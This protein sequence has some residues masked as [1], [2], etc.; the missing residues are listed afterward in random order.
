MK[1][2]TLLILTYLLLGA[3]AS[4]ATGKVPGGTNGSVL[5]QTV[6]KIRVAEEN[7]AGGTRAKKGRNFYQI[8][9]YHLKSPAQEQ[10]L[11]NFLR[12]AYLPALHRANIRKVGVFKPIQQDTA[13]IRVYVLIPFRSLSEFD[14][15]G[16]QLAKD[17]RYQQSGSDY[18]NAPYNNAPYAR[19]E[20]ILL[21]AFSGSP[22]L[23]LPKLT[24]PKSERVYE[25]RSYEGP[26]EKYYENK[27]KM[28]NAGNEIAIFNRLGFNAV[29][30][31]EVMSGS[32]MPNLMYLTTFNNQ[33]DRDAHWKAFSA[34]PDW[35]KLSALEEYKNNVSKNEQFFLRPAEYSDI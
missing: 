5:T 20:S 23:T 31:G 7:T 19:M 21:K 27:V 3:S 18:I 16:D 12:Q 13:D 1:N 24:G 14:D 26:T 30:Y 29:F 11:D 9:I 2:T 6:Q 10:R 32:R 35:K 28:F 25:L 34:D 22:E 33:A 8:K 4:H 15:L 17:S